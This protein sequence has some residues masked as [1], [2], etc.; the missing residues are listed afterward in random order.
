MAENNEKQNVENTSETTEATEIT[1]ATET[2]EATEQTQEKKSVGR[3]IFEWIYTLAIAIVI[4][5]LIK[6]YVFDV[7][8]V[9]GKSMNPTLHNQDRL[10]VT[11][12]GYQPKQGDIIILDSTY[13]AREAY[14]ETLEKAEGKEYGA[15]SRFF[16]YFEL[17]PDLKK[18]Y[19]VKRVI[20]TPGQT[21]DL[22]DGRVYIDGELLEEEYYQGHTF[23]IDPNMIYPLTVEEDTVFVM[24]D[25]REH[26][27]DSRSTELGLVP[28]DAVLGKS[29]VRVFPFNAIG[30]TK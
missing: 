14:Y 13:K 10:I 11:K 6:G 30:R 16:H 26:S 5:F 22:R 29:Q 3:E 1:E 2:T 12:L 9:D 19:Y 27:K 7:V 4:A 24:G 25:N 21:V 18:K 28:Y 15:V 17:S 8:K 23:S 20:A